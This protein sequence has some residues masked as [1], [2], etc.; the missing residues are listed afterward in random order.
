MDGNYLSRFITNKTVSR[1]KIELK[2][3]SKSYLNILGVSEDIL[4]KIG[5]S[6]KTKKLTFDS[7]YKSLLPTDASNKYTIAH[8]LA[9][10]NNGVFTKKRETTKTRVNKRETFIPDEAFKSFQYNNLLKLNKDWLKYYNKATKQ[11]SASPDTLDL[12][13]CI[14]K[15]ISS[16]LNLNN[17]G[18]SNDEVF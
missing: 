2:R 9:Q 5:L 11:G 6:G 8:N 15:Q 4:K 12:H 7:Y 16:N 1:A 18:E 14:M 10:P 13:F 3:D 17:Y